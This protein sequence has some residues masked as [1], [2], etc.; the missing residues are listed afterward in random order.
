MTNYAY[1]GHEV[2]Q[3]RFATRARGFRRFA[4]LG[5]GVTN[6]ALVSCITTSPPGTLILLSNGV[7]NIGGANVVLATN[8]FLLGESMSNTVVYGSERATRLVTASGSTLANFTYTNFTSAG[9]GDYNGGIGNAPPMTNMNDVVIVNLMLFGM[10]D[11]FRY[12]N[13]LF[14]VKIYNSLAFG[15]W[16]NLTCNGNSPETRMLLCNC[17]FYTDDTSIGNPYDGIRGIRFGGSGTV[18]VNHCI[19]T[20]WLGGPLAP[21][22]S[23]GIQGEQTAMVYVNE[24]SV[25]ISLAPGVI[26]YM[27]DAPVSLSSVEGGVIVGKGVTLNQPVGSCVYY[28]P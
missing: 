13:G 14:D 16:D 24:T 3:E 19:I 10:E 28:L 20:N 8:C 15:R 21:T 6:S 17:Y 11:T 9:P 25:S 7:H 23:C 12:N 18:T 1:M 26:D 22:D 5:I 4:A 27:L 2:L